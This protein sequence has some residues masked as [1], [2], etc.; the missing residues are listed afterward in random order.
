MRKGR[1]AKIEIHNNPD[2]SRQLQ[3]YVGTGGGR[4]LVIRDV[5]QGKTAQDAVEAVAYDALQP[6]G[7]AKRTF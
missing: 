5:P 1:I 4:K 7:V 6:G 3:L 2:G